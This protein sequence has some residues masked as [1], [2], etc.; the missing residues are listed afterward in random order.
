MN[1]V[2]SLI[3]MATYNG[4]SWISAQLDSMQAQSRD[5]WQLLVS[6]DGSTD[7]T[8]E[9]VR[10]RAD[11]DSRITLLP[12]RGGSP[13][14]VANFEYLLNWAAVYT[15]DA[16]FLSDQDDIWLPD[17]LARQRDDL[18]GGSVAACSDLALIDDTG[19]QPASFWQRMRLDSDISLH[20][21]LTQNAVVGCSLAFRPRLLE[22]AL[23]FPQQLQNHD[24][25]L[26]L[27]A[28]VTD[29]LYVNPGQLLQYRQHDGNTI[30]VTD[31][32]NQWRR[33]GDILRRQGRIIESKA[34]AVDELVSRLEQARLAVPDEL[35]F[36]TKAF[37]GR[38][39]LARARALTGPFRPRSRSLLLVQLLALLR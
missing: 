21:H 39:R 6:D 19:M 22:L 15:C 12:G 13:G 38:G 1:E 14:H 23:P 36:F 9:L 3:V 20:S 17:K 7:G 24:W 32:R 4:G 16:I 27:C 29:G 26:A 8:G 25:W 34:V 28:L 35:R 11:A 18:T 10:A 30:G 33:R 31:R 5:N 37:R 2:D